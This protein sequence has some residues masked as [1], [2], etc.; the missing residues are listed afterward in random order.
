MLEALDLFKGISDMDE[1]ERRLKDISGIATIEKI[2]NPED[3][4][5]SCFN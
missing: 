5:S 1:I 2:K 3:K 4:T